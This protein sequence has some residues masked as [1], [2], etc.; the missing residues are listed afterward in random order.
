MDSAKKHRHCTNKFV[1]VAN[2]LQEEGYE[3]ELISAAMMAASGIYVTYVA[4]GN[5]GGLE[6]S[7]VNKAV[8]FYR[9]TLE[10]VQT[11]KREQSANDSTENNGVNDKL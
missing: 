6:P 5:A 3:K 11:S 4:A 1:D 8:T 9:Q 10:Q 2:K 7:G